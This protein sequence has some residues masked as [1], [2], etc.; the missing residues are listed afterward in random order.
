M[1]KKKAKGES[2]KNIP[3]IA[4]PTIAQVLDQFLEAQ[5]HRLKPR[6]LSPYQDI[7]DLLKDCLNG[8]AYNYLDKKESAWLDRLEGEDLEFC[9]LFGPEKILPNLDEFLSYFM[10]RKVIA[11]KELLRA[12]GTVTKQLAK[13]LAAAGYANE[14]DVEEAM[15]VGAEAADALPRAEELA[16]RLYGWAES[17]GRL[18]ILEQVDSR[19]TVDRVAPGKIWLSDF[20]GRGA[21]GPIAVPR[22]ISDR[23]EEGWIITL[24]LGRSKKGWHIK[25]WHILE[26]G[27]VYPL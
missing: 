22:D 1:T 7:I 18:E 19:F 12:A 20:L 21:Y 15:T 2:R 10:V 6:T 17:Q 14:A 23:C 25:G 4:N 9:D 16:M 8:Y 5:R 13:W 3:G 24:L 26:V 11:G 27:N